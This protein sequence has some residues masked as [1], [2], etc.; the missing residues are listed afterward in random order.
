MK[1]V[2]ILILTVFF[3]FGSLFANAQNSAEGE[4]AKKIRHIDAAFQRALR[5]IEFRSEMKA[6]ELERQNAESAFAIKLIESSDLDEETKLL[7]I[8]KIRKESAE[9]KRNL[10]LAEL[11]DSKTKARLNT[12]AAN[13]RLQAA[14]ERVNSARKLVQATKIEAK[15]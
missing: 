8:S 14:E 1:R 15:K 12:G 9:R 2:M 5:E 4:Y 3:I 11:E 10:E 13:A 6:I 7:N